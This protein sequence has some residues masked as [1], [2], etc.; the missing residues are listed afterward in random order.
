MFH[1]ATIAMTLNIIGDLFAYLPTLWKTYRHPEFENLSSWVLYLS[2][3]ILSVFSISH[4]TYGIAVHPLYLVTL[5]AIMCLLI[6]RGRLKKAKN[7][8]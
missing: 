8:V 6:L 4:W 7:N 2:G 1:N 3:Y 5:G